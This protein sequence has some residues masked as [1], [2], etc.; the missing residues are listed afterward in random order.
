MKDEYR[1]VETPS[2]WVEHKGY[3]KYIIA[4]YDKYENPP[5]ISNESFDTIEE[6]K[7]FATTIKVEVE[8]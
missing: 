5:S 4:F 7:E 2:Y 8:E 3:K 1:I 6:A